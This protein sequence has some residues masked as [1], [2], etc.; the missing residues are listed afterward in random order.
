LVFL[1]THTDD[2][3]AATMNSPDQGVFGIPADD[4]S[5]ASDKLEIAIHSG[6]LIYRGMLKEDIV[7]GIFTHGG[8]T[9]LDLIL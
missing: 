8:F 6:M 3:L 1:I 4:I 7:E 2:G 9:P 5:F